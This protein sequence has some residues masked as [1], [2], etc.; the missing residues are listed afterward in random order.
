[1]V[2]ENYFWLAFS[3]IKNK[4]YNTCTCLHFSFIKGVSDLETC[5]EY[6]VCPEGSCVFVFI[7][8]FILNDM[9]LSNTTV[10][11]LPN[12]F[13]LVRLGKKVMWEVSHKVSSYQTLVKR[14]I[15]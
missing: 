15:E 5:V 8:P 11:D 4:F 2:C 10:N 14:P 1:M 13:A 3:Q 12:Q 6:F 9:L 7:A